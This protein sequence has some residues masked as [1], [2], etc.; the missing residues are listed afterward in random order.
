MESLSTTLAVSTS[1]LSFLGSVYIC[2]IYVLGSKN[3]DRKTFRRAVFLAVSDG[4][5]SL[6]WLL[7]YAD[8][9]CEAIGALKLYAFLSNSF[10]GLML[11]LSILRA[12]W[13][14]P[15]LKWIES[16]EWIQ[17]VICWTAPLI[18]AVISVSIGSLGKDEYWCWMTRDFLLARA[19]LYD[20]PAGCIVIANVLVYSAAS[21]KFRKIYRLRVIRF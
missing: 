8:A 4:L 19:L 10:W 9:R 2:V 3:H 15:W 18:P 21:W 6:F 13:Q 5:S 7:N 14:S 11:S 12:F 20:L 1:S 17:H 16:S